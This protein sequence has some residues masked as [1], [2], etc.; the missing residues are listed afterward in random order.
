MNSFFQQA[1]TVWAHLV[2]NPT[3]LA[4]CVGVGGAVAVALLTLWGVRITVRTSSANTMRQIDA[5]ANQARLDRE[6]AAYQAH[7]E[8]IATA[9]RVVYLELI[10][11]VERAKAFIG[12]LPQREMDLRQL[13]AGVQP[14]LEA[15]SKLTVVAELETARLA[16]DL[17]STLMEQYMKGL[18]LLLSLQDLKKRAEN[19]ERRVAEAE[20][21]KRRIASAMEEPA[22]SGPNEFGAL[23]RLFM[24]QHDVISKYSK[25]LLSVSDEL[26]AINLARL[27]GLMS[28]LIPAGDRL[29]ELLNAMRIELGL[30]SDLEG[31]R[32]QTAEMR[33]RAATAIAG[34]AIATGGTKH[35]L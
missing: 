5:S 3:V 11:E 33:D 1:A 13:Q 4:A 10:V 22:E 25:E 18:G 35:P 30:A 19:A 29:D 34:F 26:L 21:E 16:R 14:L 28:E 17:L 31:F 2:A 7:N 32:K 6:D 20:L 9:R 27:S 12:S 23:Q 24:V 8:R 15:V